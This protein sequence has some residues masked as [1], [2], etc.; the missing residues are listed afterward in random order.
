MQQRNRQIDGLRGITILFIVVF[1]MI[2]SYS[3]NFLDIYP[4]ILMINRWGVVG[5][6]L[7]LIISGYFLVTDKAEGF[8]LVKK[9][10]KR[11]WPTYF[12][13]ITVDFILTRF[14]SLPNRTITITDYILNIP[15]LN[16]FIGKPYLDAGHWYLTILI[17][18]IILF[19]L[20]NKAPIN[21]RPIYI[22]ITLLVNCVLFLISSLTQELYWI[23]YLLAIDG[24]AYLPLICAGAGIYYINSDKNRCLGLIVYGM[25]LVAS[26]I[27]LKVQYVPV[28]LLASVVFWIVLKGKCSFMESRILL[29]LG[30]ISYSLYVTH[31]L[32]GFL[33]ISYLQVC[34]GEYSIV[35]SIFAVLM[36]LVY[37]TLVHF[38]FE[39]P[40]SR[41][42]SKKC[43]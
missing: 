25:S 33:L 31:A 6:T 28:V 39:L 2:Y 41:A 4:S 24:G 19:S 21:R 8:S 14:I 3:E 13:S 30:D 35:F 10:I 16:G 17:G 36:C 42:L 32:F 22:L 1:H 5:Y 23:R 34:F 37:A 26:V 40:V 20:I 11:L 29:F 7:F 38:Y 43:R 12:L 27:L 18:A 15:F 9:R